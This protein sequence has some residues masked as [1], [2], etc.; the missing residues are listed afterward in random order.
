MLISPFTVFLI[1]AVFTVLQA[2][3]YSGFSVTCN[4]NRLYGRSS[5]YSH[6]ATAERDSWA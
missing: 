2:R 4:D 3:V 5:N 1:L 6:P